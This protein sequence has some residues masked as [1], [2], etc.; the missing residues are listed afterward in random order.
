MPDSAGPSLDRLVDIMRRLRA[1]D[2]CPWD[3]VQTHA[4]LRPYVLEETYE[5]LE[6]LDTGDADAIKEELGDY[7]F[8]AVFLAHISAEHGDFSIG[9]ALDT[10]CLKLVRRHPHVFE[11]D[12]ST[13]R[14][15]TAA[16]VLERWDDLKARERALAGTHQASPRASTLDSVPSTLPALLRAYK[17]GRQASRAG[18]DWPRALDVVAKMEEEVAEIQ[19]AVESADTDSRGHLEEEI[20]DLLFAIANLSRKLDI[21]PETALRRAC[22]KFSKRFAILEQTFEASGER[23]FDQSLDRLEAA[24]QRAKTASSR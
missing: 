17:L 11:R 1:P 8:E 14:P 4:S 5:L 23:M 3:Q 2:G 13:E 9:D 20:G 7:L 24:W 10:V 21:E 16:Q 18:F 19:Q 22:T 15:T 12:T 6:A